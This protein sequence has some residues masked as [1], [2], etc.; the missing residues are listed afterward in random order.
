MDIEIQR[1][2][3]RKHSLDDLMRLLYN[4]YHKA[5]GR[6]FSEEEFWAAVDEVA[7][8]SMSHIRH[9]VDNPVDIDYEKYLA[10]AGLILDRNTWT[11]KP[12]N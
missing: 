4:R 7:G 10:P 2:S 11:I 1:L 3:N 5:Q 6:G 12:R 9:I 8:A